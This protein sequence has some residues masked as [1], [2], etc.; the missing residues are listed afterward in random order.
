[1]SS[2]LK[3]D[4]IADE[5][6]FNSINDNRFKTNRLS[7]NFITPLQE[8]TASLNAVLPFVLEKCSADYPDVTL[9]S[10]KLDLLYGAAVGGSVSKIGD[11]Q[12]I[13]VAVSTIDDKYAL[14]GEKV[15]QQIAEILSSLVFNPLINQDAFDSNIFELEKSNL[16]DLIE[17]EI[18]EKRSYSI[19]RAEQIMYENEPTGISRLGTVETAR[20]LTAQAAYKAYKKLISSARIEIFFTGCGDSQTARDIFS[21]VVSKL[22][23]SDIVDIKTRVSVPDKPQRKTVDKMDVVQSKLVMGYKFKGSDNDLSALRF[24]IS[25]FG[26]TP[27]SKLFVNVREKLSLCY[28]CAARFDRIKCT[29]MVDSGVESE[30][31]EKAKTEIENQLNEIKLGNISDDEYE[32]T[33]LSLVNSFK[34]IYDSAAGLETWY[35]GQ[36]VSGTDYDPLSE[37]EK[38]ADVS[39]QDIAKAAES[40]VLDTVYILTGRDGEDE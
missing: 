6:Y 35:L 13:S 17:S 14:D 3:T 36:R 33:R 5:V 37:A 32:H 11:N 39:K 23:R 16:I 10:Q 12:C 4:K 20:R 29:M 18:N 22:F 24:M 1:M 21:S 34:A 38:L 25:L 15:S 27:V 28:Y 8:E 26:G 31:I 2:L 7:V 30:N 40:A 9:L 19:K